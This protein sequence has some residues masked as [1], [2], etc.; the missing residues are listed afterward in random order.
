MTPPDPPRSGRDEPPHDPK[1]VRESR[2]SR[3]SRGSRGTGG[4]AS[5]AAQLRGEIARHDR[6]YHQEGAPEISDAEYDRLF[7]ELAELEAAHPELVRPDSPTQR[8]GAPIPEGQGLL[9]VPHAVPMLSIDSLFTAEEVREF[10]RRVLRFL[11]LGEARGRELAWVCEPKYDGVSIALVYER[12]RLARALTRGDGRVGEDVTHSART[13][14]N[15]PLEL[16]GAAIPALLEVRGEVLIHRRAFERFNAARAAAGD[17]VLANPR[18]A[19]AG[20]LRRSDPAEVARYPLEFRPWAVERAEGVRFDTYTALAE[21]LQ[22]WGLP[23]TGRR[24][25]ALGIEACIAYHDALEARRDQEPFDMDGVVA[26][27][28]DLELRERLGRTSRSTRWQ[29][30]HKFTPREVTSTLLAIEVQVGTNG[31]LTPRAHLEPVEVGGVTVSH[32]TLHNADR[33]AALDLA[34]GDRVFLERAGDV[35]PQ[36]TGVA[37]KAPRQAPAGWKSRIPPELVEASGAPRAG[38][39]AGH[40]ERF[41]PPKRC[42]ACGAAT[43]SSGKYWLCPAG[44]ACRPQLVGRTIQLLGGDGFDVPELGEKKIQQLAEHGLLRTPADVF[45]LD[46]AK[47]VELERWGEKSV[48]SLMSEL[49][50]GRRLPLD[51]FVAALGIPDVGRATARLL[52][53]HHRSWSELAAAR[54]D[55]L[56]H[57]DGIGPELAAALPAWTAAPAN[58]ALVARLLAGG[59]EVVPME[60]RGSGALAGKTFV[61]TGTLAGMTRAEAKQ[62]IEAAGAKVASAVSSRT[63]YVVAGE[64]SGSKLARATELGV[65]VLTEEQFL[66]LLAGA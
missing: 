30:A 37:E 20:A 29:F 32:A 31:R 17:P 11:G 53:R 22:S 16:C 48:A 19:A 33:V 40:G 23:D 55:E 62:R 45:H 2:E 28:D 35:I 12:G 27:L 25:R 15:L 59:V 13:I 42:P 64:E 60:A 34:V 18:N 26:K 21:A 41:V 8:V 61:L 66:G 24:E 7:R 65:R 5:R 14:R 38:V 63:D 49:E 1:V 54:A 46:A 10:E 50:R 39:T 57:I 36:I 4:P 44:L 56:L 3:G 47:L 9:K 43:Q 51:R 6:L 58:R 52:A